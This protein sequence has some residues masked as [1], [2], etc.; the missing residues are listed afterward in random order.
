MIN[1]QGHEMMKSLDTK[2]SID[3][4]DII[5]ISLKCV[6]FTAHHDMSRVASR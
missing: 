2:R 4:K 5:F 1:G 6:V 3:K